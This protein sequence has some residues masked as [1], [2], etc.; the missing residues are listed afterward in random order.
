MAKLTFYGATEGVT[1][2]AYLLETGQATNIA[3]M[4]SFPGRPRGG[5]S[6]RKAVSVRYQEAA[7]RWWMRVRS[8]SAI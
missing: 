7:W 6:Q 1:G 2:S 5:D 4:R 8:M 3:G